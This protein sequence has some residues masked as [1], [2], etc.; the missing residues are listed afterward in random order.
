MIDVIGT[1]F[2]ALAIVHTF[3][4]S[5]FH[6]QADKFEKGSISHGVFHFLGEI[7]VVFGLWA[8]LFLIVYIGVS[9]WNTAIGYMDSLHFT[10]P[11][12]VF[13]IMVISATRPVLEAAR[14]F[15]Q[16]VSA[17]LQKLIPMQPQLV[18]I[19][20][21]LILGPL[22]GSLI[23]EPAAITV[24]ALLLKNMIQN[25]SERMTYAL[26]AVLFVNISIGGAL[27]PFAAPP[28][29]MVAK[30]WGWDFA[31][32]ISH[33]GWKSTAAVFVNAV[34]FTFYFRKEI[35]LGFISLQEIASKNNEMKIPIGVVLVHFIFLG[36]LIL[37][38]HHPNV[39][40][41]LLMLFLGVAT[42]TR[43]YQH[44]LRLKESLLVAFFLAGIIVFGPF[45]S[46]WLQPLLQSLSDG[47][48]FWSATF[49]TAVTDNAA[50]TYLGTQVTGLSDASKYALVAGAIAGGGLTIIANA[51][52][53]AGYSILNSKFP[54]GSMS[55][56]KLLIA[57]LIP[58]FIAC[59]FLFLIPALK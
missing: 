42:V 24:T 36:L 33:F 13:A 56:I 38:S 50:L 4:V 16:L 40:M 59:V 9:D 25:N 29:L 39:F 10:E 41:G 12:F 2:F 46:W 51:P 26:L 57:A 28:I 31:F 58:T 14:G 32:T 20:V 27:T 1:L 5:F 55:P 15:I 48:L 18:D 35:Q 23:T 37:T 17:G 21:L 34:L 44:V 53:A 6:K 52:N 54:N 47:A 19:C 30:P 3:L 11:L 7:E 45:Q 22:S 8:A 49:L 43:S